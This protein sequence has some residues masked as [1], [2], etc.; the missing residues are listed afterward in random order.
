MEAKHVVRDSTNAV[1]TCSDWPNLRGKE[2]L[3]PSPCTVFC[4]V[5]RSPS[6][7]I[8][9]TTL[10]ELFA[11]CFSPA[12]SRYSL[13]TLALELICHLIYPFRW[14]VDQL[15]KQYNFSYMFKGAHCEAHVTHPIQRCHRVT[16]ATYPG[17]SN[18]DGLHIDMSTKCLVVFILYIII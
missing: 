12:R 5:S 7:G 16:H 6:F 3:D 18:D 11:L 10:E 13:L 15:L 9:Q 2:S 17:Q 14:Q 1:V 8:L 4:L